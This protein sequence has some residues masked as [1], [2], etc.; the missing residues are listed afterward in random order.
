[1]VFLARH[2]LLPIHRR[3]K[4]LQ[5]YRRSR[6]DGEVFW[7]F[8]LCSGSLLCPTIFLHPFIV[9]F[10]CHTHTF[11]SQF[12][13]LPYPSFLPLC[14]S[15]SFPFFF[16]PFPPFFLQRG[17]V[18][19]WSWGDVLGP[20]GILHDS[21]MIGTGFRGWIFTTIVVLNPARHFNSSTYASSAYPIKTTLQ[22]GLISCAASA[23]AVLYYRGGS[24]WWRCAAGL[25][26]LPRASSA[27]SRFS[28]GVDRLDVGLKGTNGGVG[29]WE[30]AGIVLG[31]LPLWVGGRVGGRVALGEVSLVVASA[32]AWSWS[33]LELELGNDGRRGIRGDSAIFLAPFSG[34][35]LW[36]LSLAVVGSSLGAGR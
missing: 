18:F 2:T 8:G 1:M 19:L 15:K 29:D 5:K 11:P 34:M 35:P 32:W 33:E 28:S 36:C 9:H 17:A 16:S 26:G 13:C 25:P 14:F 22:L 20:P 23:K 10:L 24:S 21:C 12:T 3:G 27:P 6:T 30:A 31:L 7:S 4:K